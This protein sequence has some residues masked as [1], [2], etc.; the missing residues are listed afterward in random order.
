MLKFVNSDAMPHHQNPTE[1]YLEE[2]VTILSQ[3]IWEGGEN[4][5]CLLLELIGDIGPFPQRRFL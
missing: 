2:F 3:E 4:N 1:Q 5:I